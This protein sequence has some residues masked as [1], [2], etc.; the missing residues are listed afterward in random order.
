MLLI[1]TEQEEQSK[2]NFVVERGVP[3]PAARNKANT[4]PFK[5]M[6]VGDSFETPKGHRTRLS[7]AAR[8]YAEKYGMRFT[9]RTIGDACRV[10]RIK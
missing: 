6:S 4:Y 3:L 1:V 2:S 9:T 8:Y 7:V 10:W 5:Y